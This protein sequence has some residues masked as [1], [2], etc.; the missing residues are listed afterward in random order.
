MPRPLRA[1]IVR[2]SAAALAPAA[3]PGRP[4]RIAARAVPRPIHFGSA[5]APP[6]R[7]RSALDVLLLLHDRLA[8]SVMLFWLA[9]GLWGVFAWLRG[10]AVSGS[11]AGALAIGVALVVVQV[12]AGVG[13]FLA[14]ARPGQATHYLYGITA[15]LVVPFAWSYLRD[16]DQRQALMVYALLALFVFGL[17]IRGMTTAGG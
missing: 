9:V 11:Y 15:I 1:G 14:G 3:A 4:S 16:R 2:A 5:I 6:H 8:T 7:R 13:L 10:G 17:A 12:A